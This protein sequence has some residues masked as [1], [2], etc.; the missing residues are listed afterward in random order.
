MRAQ[1]KTLAISSLLA[2]SGM[3]FANEKQACPDGSLTTCLPWL[4]VLIAQEEPAIENGSTSNYAQNIYNLA[5]YASQ[6]HIRISSKSYDQATLVNLI[7]QLRALYKK[8]NIDI[9]LGFHPDNDNTKVDLNGWTGNNGACKFNGKDTDWKCAMGPSIGYMNEINQNFSGKGQDRGFD[10]FSIEQ[11]YVEVDATENLA[12]QKACLGNTVD[13]A[14]CPADV[15]K[16]KYPTKYATVAPSCGAPNQYG[17]N[18]FD[19][20]YP[21]FYN[22]QHSYTAP[23]QSEALPF[24]NGTYESPLQASGLYSI[25]DADTNCGWANTFKSKKDITHKYISDLPSNICPNRKAGTVSTVYQNNSYEIPAAYLSWIITNKWNITQYN[26]AGVAGALN[27]Y[28]CNNE[29]GLGSLED[30]SLYFTLSGEVDFLGG[31]YWTLENINKF[32][33]A[34]IR[35]LTDSTYNGTSTTLPTPEQVENMKFAIWK[36][37]PIINQNKEI[38]SKKSIK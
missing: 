20:S 1:L 35:N 5:P 10:I 3:S 19:Y 23:A 28:P 27:S 38:L 34:F 7:K 32:H 18:A 37:Q 26:Q 9:M 30:F 15:T 11:S 31:K 21:Q 12:Q 33:S 6:I 13:N 29:A 24:M 2:V 8:G 36:F 25:V 16:A 4:N 22:L 14:S 17:K